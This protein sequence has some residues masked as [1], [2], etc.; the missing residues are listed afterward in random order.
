[1]K[2]PDKSGFWVTTKLYRW[3]RRWRRKTHFGSTLK[4]KIFLQQSTR[5]KQG[6]RRCMKIAGLDKCNLKGSKYFYVP[7]WSKPKWAWHVIIN[8]SL[9]NVH[10]C[11]AVCST[12]HTTRAHNLNINSLIIVCTCFNL[13]SKRLESRLSTR[14]RMRS[15]L[16]G[17]VSPSLTFSITIFIFSLM[18]YYEGYCT[19]AHSAA[20]CDALL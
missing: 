2:I 15:T 17:M 12:V 19:H 11:Y 10:R 16:C 8:A 6:E 20:W 4:D 7:W 14:P 9:I 3:P 5:K 1:M 18:Q 13:P